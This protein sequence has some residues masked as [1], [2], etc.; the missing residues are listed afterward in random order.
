[1]LDG[2]RDVCAIDASGLPLEEMTVPLRS[3]LRFAHGGFLSRCAVTNERC[4]V[5]ANA[6]VGILSQAGMRPISVEA[7][8]R[9]GELKTTRQIFLHRLL[10]KIEIGLEHSRSLMPGS[11]RCG[12]IPGYGVGGEFRHLRQQ[13][14]LRTSDPTLGRR[15]ILPWRRGHPEL[16]GFTARLWRPSATGSATP[17]VYT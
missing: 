13:Q 16:F 7:A 6:A 12:L 3:L 9:T 8:P 5:E 15:I 10:C 17:G 14:A 1:M 2:R 11:I 4:Y